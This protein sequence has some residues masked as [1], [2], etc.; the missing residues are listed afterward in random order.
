MAT[1][2]RRNWPTL[3]LVCGVDSGPIRVFLFVFM[4]ALVLTSLCTLAWAFGTHRVDGEEEAA[5]LALDA[6]SKGDF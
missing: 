1:L 3:C 2:N 5:R 6:E 4:G